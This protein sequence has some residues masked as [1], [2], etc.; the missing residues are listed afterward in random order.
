MTVRSTQ[1][2]QGTKCNIFQKA[3]FYTLA[4]SKNLRLKDVPIVTG[5]YV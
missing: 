4:S 1:L 5:Q 3:L 2:Q